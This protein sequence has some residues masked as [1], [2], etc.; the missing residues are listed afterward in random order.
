MELEKLIY[1]ID[2]EGRLKTQVDWIAG[3]NFDGYILR[4]YLRFSKTDNTVK[5][6][7]RVIDSSRYDGIIESTEIKGTFYETDKA[8]ITCK[9]E[10]FEMRGKILGDKNQYIAFSINGLHSNTIPNECYQMN[11]I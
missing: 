9:F 1:D 7:T 2:Y 11:G 3:G 10:N 6:I 4:E 5:R 8:T